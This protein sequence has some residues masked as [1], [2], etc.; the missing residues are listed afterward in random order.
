MKIKIKKFDFGYEI[1][2]IPEKKKEKTFLKNW[3]FYIE[4]FFDK[5]GN[6]RLLI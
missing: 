4:K 5:E 6:L 3:D 2:I 1:K